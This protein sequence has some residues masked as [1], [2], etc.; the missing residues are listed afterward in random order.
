MVENTVS[1]PLHAS[2]F[3]VLRKIL[4]NFSTQMFLM[5]TYVVAVTKLSMF[6]GGTYG[7][8]GPLDTRNY[9]LVVKIQAP[10]FGFPSLVSNLQ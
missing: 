9:N 2:V 7:G 5:W 3:F 10:E 8:S 4:Y 1:H 6:S